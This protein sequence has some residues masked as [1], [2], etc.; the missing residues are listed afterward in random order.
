MH[1]DDCPPDAQVCDAG[2]GAGLPVQDPAQRLH[3]GQVWRQHHGAPLPQP[4][5][6]SSHHAGSTLLCLQCY[7]PEP[8]LVHDSAR[9]LHL[10]KCPVFLPECSCTMPV[11]VPLFMHFGRLDTLCKMMP[12]ICTPL[13][14]RTLGRGGQQCSLGF[15]SCVP[16]LIQ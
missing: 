4:P 12:F 9:I 13:R 10:G 3:P 6:N 14:N 16:S 11:V 7:G 8:F 1:G 5:Y 2:G 15:R